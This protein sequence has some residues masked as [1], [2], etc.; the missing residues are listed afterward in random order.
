MYIPRNAEYIYVCSWCML[1]VV[2]LYSNN[3]FNLEL[4]LSIVVSQTSSSLS[5]SIANFAVTVVMDVTLTNPFAF[6]FYT[7]VIGFDVT[8]DDPDGSV[9]DFGCK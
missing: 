6:D 1:T 9:L 5:S 2:L 8:F 4:L 3:P 7:N